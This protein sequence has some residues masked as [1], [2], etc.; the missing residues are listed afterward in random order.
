MLNNRYIH[1][2]FNYYL[3][4]KNNFVIPANLTKLEKNEKPL[5][6]PKI[7]SK[8]T[9]IW[10]QTQENRKKKTEKKKRKKQF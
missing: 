6:M 7:A 4:F 2:C 3:N 5:A 8:P 1:L 10:K 9:P